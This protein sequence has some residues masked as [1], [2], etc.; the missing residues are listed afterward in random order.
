MK[1]L[2]LYGMYKWMKSME[3]NYEEH[4][5]ILAKDRFSYMT[6]VFNSAVEKDMIRNYD[7][8][9]FCQL[10]VSFLLNHTGKVDYESYLK[11]VEFIKLEPIEEQNYKELQ[12]TFSDNLDDNLI[13]VLGY[14]KNFF[15]FYYTTII[16][17]DK[18]DRKNELIEFIMLTE[19][20]YADNDK[21]VLELRMERSLT[22]IAMMT[23]LEE[24]DMD[25][26]PSSFLVYD[27]FDKD[28]ICKYVEVLGKT[29]NIT[30]IEV[31]S[32]AHMDYQLNEKWHGIPFYIKITYNDDEEMNIDCRSVEGCESCVFDIKMDLFVR[33]S[34]Y[35]NE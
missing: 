21:L 15:K 32:T 11:Y 6:N 5:T 1:G 27:D 17:L 19:L 25:Y 12:E 29:I 3:M 23:M 2:G 18:I 20:L 30:N 35:V 10:L 26:S 22:D 8:Y 16:K 24:L 31:D 13:K 7:C 28:F 33:L 34:E 14:F 9:N 4:L